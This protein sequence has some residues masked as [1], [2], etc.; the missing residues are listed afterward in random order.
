MVLGVAA[1]RPAGD[2]SPHLRSSSAAAD[3]AKGVVSASPASPRFAATPVDALRLLLAAGAR[4]GSSLTL[5][6]PLEGAV[7]ALVELL[8]EAESAAI[9]LHDADT[10]LLAPHCF[11]GRAADF[12]KVRLLPGEGV[13]GTAFQ[14]QETVRTGPLGDTLAPDLHA[15]LSP[16]NASLLAGLDGGRSLG[17]STAVPL[18][19]GDGHLV[20][21]LTVGSG[22]AAFTDDDVRL[23]EGVA[24]QLGVALDNARLYGEVRRQAEERRLLNEF[25]RVASSSLDLEAL[26]DRVVAEVLSLTG[27]MRCRVVRHEAEADVLRVL[28]GRT[29]GGTPDHWVGNS[30]D[31][32]GDLP[33]DR[34]PGGGANTRV[35]RTGRSVAVAD[36]LLEPPFLARDHR[37]DGVRS[38]ASVPIAVDGV[39]WGTLNVAFAEPG[40]ATVDCVALLEGVAAHLALAVRN[41]RLYGEVRRQAEERRLLNEFARVASSSLDLPALLDR[42]TTEVLALADALRCRVVRHDPVTNTVTV[43]VGQQTG[44][45]PD[46]TVGRARQI[47]AASA[48]AAGLRTGRTVTVGDTRLMQSELADRH[49]ASGV[50]SLACVPI[51][52]GGTVWGMLNVAF[53]EPGR[54]TPECVALLEGVAAHLALAIHNA[55]LYEDAQREIADRAVAEQRLRESSGQRVE[56]AERL[57]STLGAVAAA[58]TLEGALRALLA[59]AHA[60]VG[61]YKCVARLLDP[62]TGTC[63][64]H[65]RID[66]VGR[67]HRW[68]LPV[69]PGP[70]SFTTLLDGGGAAVLVED[71][72]ALAGETY[73]YG[74]DRAR[75]GSR[76]ALHV[77]VDAGG[78]RIGTLQFDHRE[79]G[80][81]TREHL[82]LAV[83]LASQAGSVIARTRATG[84]LR[85][86]LAALGAAQVRLVQQ[87]RLKALGQLAAGI[88]HDLNNTLAPVVGFSELLLA[89]ARSASA[90]GSPLTLGRPEQEWLD[91]LHAGALDAAEV[92]RRLREFYRQRDGH[93]AFAPVDLAAVVAQTV[94][95]TRPRWKDDAQATGRTVAVRTELASDLPPVAGSAPELREALTNLLINAVDA[96]PGGGVIT[97]R[98]RAEGTAVVL[99]VVDTGA[100]MDA[101]TRGR[102]L[103]PFFTTKGE[104]GTGLGLAMVHGTVQRHGGTL[105]ID[106]TP[107]TG[108]TVRLRLPVAAPATSMPAAGPDSAGDGGGA[109]GAGVHRPL[110]PLRLLVVDDEPAVRLVTAA[111]LEADGHVVVQAQD[112]SGGLAA[113]RGGCFD[114]LVTDRAMPGGMS[115]EQLAAAAKALHPQ[116]PVLLLTGYGDLMIAA[117]ERSACVDTVLSKPVTLAALRDALEALTPAAAPGEGRQA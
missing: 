65:L 28:A 59:G 21:V 94:E 6:A 48:N 35:V 15:T 79:P 68:E 5:D 3:A 36:T 67:V 71:Y 103:E 98:T 97:V 37:V 17:H 53:A 23:L 73:P 29:S 115:G 60:L 81:Y 42:V 111:L 80:Y 74:E 33:A 22:R 31:I 100:G 75:Q 57:A 40:K 9:L 109:Q 93:D 91:L 82:A 11:V 108:T 106:S 27:A 39:V 45:E 70:G 113:L 88:A 62:E 92:V 116:L 72:W 78:Q 7:A 50:R 19:A 24:A 14:R 90:A 76:S 107:G 1:R 25:A 110:R 26:L 85:A 104:T 18:R 52:I 32:G 20:G 4:T 77:P 47:E 12:K 54:T 2:T 117:G 43:M 51:T 63:V 44:G 95:L 30:W 38:L 102:C 96:L 64:M 55:Q 99:E 13:S 84:Q 87:E 114:A 56:A 69:S 16:Q 101:E 58:E 10:G 34:P 83:A 66:E 86:A 41:T 89:R 105:E 112:G 61:G 8:P 46:T 49:L